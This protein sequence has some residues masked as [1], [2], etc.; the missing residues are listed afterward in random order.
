MI[1]ASVRRAVAV[2]SGKTWF[3]HVPLSL[4]VALLG[5]LHLIPVIDQAMAMH[6]HLGTPGSVRQDLVGVSLLG[7]SQLSISAFLLIMAFGLW[8]RSRIAWWL[9]VLAAAIGL[10]A[11]ALQPGT[12]VGVWS[13][14]YDIVLIGLLLTTRQYFDRSSMRLGTLAALAALVVL[15]GYAVFGTYRL[16][17]QFSAPIDTLTDEFYVSVVTMST[18]G[19]GDFSPATPEA[20]LFV[21]SVIIFSVTVLSTAVGTT[22]I[23]A[24]VHKI[25]EVNIGKHSR[26]NRTEHYIIVGYSALSANTYR[27]L[28]ARNQKVTIILRNAQDSAL[29]PGTDVDIVMGDGSDLE[30]LRE[31]GAEKAKAILA[32]LDDDSENAF[33]I[34]AAKELN[35]GVKTVAAANELKHL[36]R[37]R[38][39]HPDLI[40]APQVL[41]G[42]LL[43]SMLTGE[44]I[45]VKKIMGRLLGQSDTQAGTSASSASRITGKKK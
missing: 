16:G 40:I 39:V 7:I 33:V 13:F 43:T 44:R 42:E 41:G 3:P 24:L 18:V 14:G 28:V 21:V 12:P 30:T 23:P 11:L 27:E 9:S 31:A 25:E 45:D 6:L 4:G 22:L 8:L 32:L 19:F 26:M 10:V 37:I 1:N 38:R 36:N 35:I 29:F 2:L 20:R 5:L 15:F 17:D 34:L